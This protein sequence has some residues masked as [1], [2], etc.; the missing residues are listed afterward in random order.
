MT[1]PILVLA[2]A[3]PRRAELLRASGISF[4]VRV[5]DVI[6]TRRPDESPADYALRLAREKAEAVAQGDE[7]VLGA[8]TIVVLGSEIAGKP[9]DAA[10]AARMLR[11][12]SGRWHE[13]LT[14]VCLLR[15]RQARSALARTRVKFAPLSEEEIRWYVA[16]G[17]PFDKAGAY[18]IQGYASLF[19]ERIEGSYS[20][21]VGLP[22]QMVYQLARE[23]GV[24]L[25][26][27]AEI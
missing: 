4:T 7:L 27:K 20:N 23:L 5:A 12:L 22:V 14:G 18:A 15:G 6:E 24:R 9:R 8:D 16:S 1:D 2:S 19:V 26:M 10:D 21:V 17:E 25:R 13:V 3:S 11:A